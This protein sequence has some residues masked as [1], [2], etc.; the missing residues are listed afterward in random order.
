[1]AAEQN[2]TVHAQSPSSPVPLKQGVGST[3]DPVDDVE[4][5]ALEAI[6]HLC[7]QVWPFLREVFPPNNTD[8][9]T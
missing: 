5:S 8:G 4:I 1:M 6:H 9:I 3:Q 7:Q 2:F